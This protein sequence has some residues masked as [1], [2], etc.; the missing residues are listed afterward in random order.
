MLLKNLQVRT[1]VKGVETID[2]NHLIAYEESQVIRTAENGE[3][4]NHFH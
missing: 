2:T 1:S 4:C 3:I